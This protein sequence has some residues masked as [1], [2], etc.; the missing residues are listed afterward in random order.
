MD[1]NVGPRDSG[2][3]QEAFPQGFPTRLS[4]MACLPALPSDHS[5]LLIPELSMNSFC[6]ADGCTIWALPGAYWDGYLIVLLPQS[7]AAEILQL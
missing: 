3:S 6:L 7:F 4:H 2:G 5:H 1:G